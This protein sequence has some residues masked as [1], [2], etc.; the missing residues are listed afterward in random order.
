MLFNNEDRP[1]STAA[2]FLEQ[3]LE[4]DGFPV[5][6]TDDCAICLG[7]ALILLVLHVIFNLFEPYKRETHRKRLSQASSDQRGRILRLWACLP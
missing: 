1:K 4:Y 2:W 7:T 6:D 3:V 5:N